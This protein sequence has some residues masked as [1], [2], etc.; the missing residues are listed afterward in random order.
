MSKPMGTAL[1]DKAARDEVLMGKA[2]M[3]RKWMGR[4]RYLLPTSQIGVHSWAL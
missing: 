3:G 2:H 4:A 1:M